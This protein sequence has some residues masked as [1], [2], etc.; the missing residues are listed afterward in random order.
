MLMRT[1]CAVGCLAAALAI[2][3]DGSARG[4]TRASTKLSGKTGQGRNI[5]LRAKEGT[6]DLLRFTIRLRCRDGS[7]LIDEESGFEPVRLRANGSFR[8]TQVGS[9]DEVTFRGRL[10]GNHVRGTVRVTDR[11]GRYRCHS[12]LVKFR[13]AA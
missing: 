7:I 9:T 8:S 3:L 6:I 1:I 2:A 13:A 12:G 11:V 10:R 4:E 5:T